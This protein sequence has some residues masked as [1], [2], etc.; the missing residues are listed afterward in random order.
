MMRRY[1]VETPAGDEV[2]VQ[3]S[4]EEAKQRGLKPVE[5]KAKTAE[6]K[7]AEPVKRSTAQKRASVLDKAF[8]SAKKGPAG[9]A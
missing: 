3:L 9:R 8:G 6:N 1:T 5:A 2:T 7:A 4:D